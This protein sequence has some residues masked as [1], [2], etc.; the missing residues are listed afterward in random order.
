MLKSKAFTLIELLLSLAILSIL[1]LFS[2]PS[3][4]S[5][6][7]KNQVLA[8]QDDIKSAVRFAK[9]EAM[10]CGNN[11]IL[12]PKQHSNDWSQGMLLFVDNA[13]HHYKPGDKLLREWCWHTPNIRV[14][15]KGFQSKNYLLFSSDVARNAVN[16]YFEIH[17]QLQSGVTLVINRL[18]RIRKE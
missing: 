6:H 13:T 10:A 12:T 15:W 2:I 16:G 8:I 5:I 11:L 9:I 4:Y 18:G 1:L 14:T 17:G 7:Q 3:L